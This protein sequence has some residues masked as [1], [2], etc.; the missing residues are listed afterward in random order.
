MVDLGLQAS[1]HSLDLLLQ[2]YVHI[3]VFLLVFLLG[4]FANVVSK[5]RLNTSTETVT[6]TWSQAS[7]HW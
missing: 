6:S 3:G 1:L 2:L 7:S 4:T 5:W